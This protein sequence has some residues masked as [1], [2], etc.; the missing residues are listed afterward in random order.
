MDSSIFKSIFRGIRSQKLVAAINLFGLGIGLTLVMLIAS[1]LYNEFQ[2]DK[3][4]EKAQFIYQLK[5]KGFGQDNFPVTPDPIAGWLKDNFPEVELA[6]HVALFNKSSKYVTVSNSNFE[7]K[8]PAFV[9]STFFRMFSFPVAYGNIAEG[10]NNKYSIVL[11]APLSRKLFG[12][13]NPVGSTMGFCGRNLFTV[14]AVL[15]EIPANSSMQ[16]D[17]LLPFSCYTE[18]SGLESNCWRCLSSYTFVVFRSNAGD[19]AENINKT[20]NKQFPDRQSA[21]SFLPLTE[22]HFSPE[23]AVDHLFKHGDKTE[24]Y[25]FMLVAIVILFIAVVNFINLTVALSA[26][27]F[28]ENSIRKIEGASQMQLL[29]R[30]IAESVLISM[31][32][33]LVAVFLVELFFT[34]FNSLLGNPLDHSQIRQPWFYAC[35]AALGLLTGL[36]AGVYP[37]FKFSRVAVTF[38]FRDRQA[39]KT[40]S[41]RWNDGLLVFQFAISIVLI[42]SALFLN[43]Q[44]DFIQ[45]RNLGFDK[46]QLIY[47]SLPDELKSKKELIIGKLKN[48]SGIEHVVTSDAVFGLP[49]GKWGR[50]LNIDGENKLV[51]FD[52]TQASEEYI[53][54]LGLQIVQ[55]RDFD[56]L[57]PA[58]KNCFLVNESFVKKYGLTDPLNTSFVN[59]NGK[60]KIIGVV[61]DF[62]FGSL[63]QQVAPLAI[64]NSD[65]CKVLM[66]RINASSLKSVSGLIG[67]IKKS[68]LDFAPDTFLD[69]QFVD[70]QIQ[71]QYIKERKASQ[72][73]S[74][75]SFFAIFISS[76]GLFAMATLTINKQTKEIGIR[77]VN[78]ATIAEVVVMINRDFVKWVAIAFVIATPIAYYAMNKWLENFA[79][80]TELSWWIFALAGLLALG[81]ALLTVSWQSWRAAIQNPVEALRYE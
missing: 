43:R 75:F 46:E 33:T 51:M 31:A 37:A 52:C 71:R 70:T 22:V 18:Y 19:L 20:M 40:G 2:A 34:L 36:V 48:I 60:D 28:K 30:F 57:R 16:F 38:I 9:D 45:T 67:I 50:Y 61:K 10:F 13:K 41:G 65:E 55:G 64:H 77:K 14:I 81:I 25:I 79:Y 23:N 29:T 26:L 3:F 27:R 35:F 21:F 54:T 44:L 72:L 78:G 5:M 74:S 59:D 76:L 47:V 42:I 73:I 7:V 17:M 58:D 8:N 6:T 12:D 24:L 39:P 56:P 62:N 66:I 15:R 32:A 1:Y 49:F 53:Q 11:T 69:V 68:I 80:K 63:H 4:H